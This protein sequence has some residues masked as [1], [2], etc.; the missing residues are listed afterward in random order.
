M[1]VTLDRLP[2]DPDADRRGLEADLRRALAD[3]KLQLHY[4]PVI[5]A[6]TREVAGVEALLRWQCPGRGWVPPDRF[7]PLAEEIG[8]IEPITEWVLSRAGRDLAPL[9]ALC[10]PFRLSVNLPAREVRPERVAK[11]LRLVADQHG[12][13]AERL[14]FEITERTLLG[15]VPSVHAALASL[16]AAGVSLAI[17]DFGTGYSSLSYLDRYPIGRL[18]IDKSFVQRLDSSPRGRK[19]TEAILL[20]AG[21]LD[22]ETVAEGVE[23]IDQLAFLIGKGCRYIQGYL[24]SRPLPIA[25]LATFVAGFRFPEDL[26]DAALWPQGLSLPRV[27]ADNQE[28]A[29]RLFVEHVPAAVAMFDPAMRYVAVSARWLSDHR[30]ADPDVIGRCH[31][32]VVPHTPQRSREVNARC[33]AGAVERCEEDRT[34]G[35]DGRAEWTR[36]EVRP[37]TN[38]IGDVAGIIIFS[39][40]ITERKEA[41]L[42]Q[43]ES[44]QRLADLLGVASD[45]LW[46]TD[47]EHRVIAGFGDVD[48]LRAD[49]GIQG[50]RAPDGSAPLDTT[51]G[52]GAAAVIGCRRWDQPGIEPG[53]EA[54]WRAHQAELDAHRPFRGF[55][56]PRRTRDGDLVWREVSGRPVFDH[57]GRFKGY[58]GVARDVTARERAEA[59]LRAR[60]V[61]L[62]LASEMAGLGY[63]HHDMLHGRRTLSDGL[64]RILGRD[65]GSVVLDDAGRTELV[66]PDD[67]QAFA[68]TVAAAMA[69]RAPY[70]LRVRIA[71]PDGGVR[72][73]V[74]SGRPQ[75]ADDGRLLGY[76]GVV[77][78]ITDQLGT[79]AALAHSSDENQMFRAIIEA[80]PDH[81]Y[82]K[83]LESRFLVANA[84]T[85]ALF[86]LSGPDQ[87]IGKCDHDFHPKELADRFLAEERAILR[88]GRTARFEHRNVFDGETRIVSALKA[89]LRDAAGR[90]IGLVGINRDI[91]DLVRAREQAA[92]ERRTNE[93][94]RAGIE[95]LPDLFYVKD[96]EHRFLAANRA[97][98]RQVGAARV[99]DVIGRTDADFHPPDLARTYRE[100]EAA[101]LAG[102]EP[103]LLQQPAR[104]AD[105]TPGW[106]ASLKSPLRD[107][108]GTL[109][110]LVGHASDI[111]EQKRQ[112]AALQS[113]AEELR[114]LSAMVIR[115]AQ[116]AERLRDLLAE[117]AAAVSDGVALF[118][119]QDRLVLCND[120]FSAAYGAAPA[121][122]LGRSFEELQRNPAFRARLRLDDAGFEAWL[123]KRLAAHR[124]ATGTPEEWERD[125]QWGLVRE[126]RAKDGSIVLSRA[127][128]T[129]LKRVEQDL[130]QLAARDALT[131]L[132]SRRDFVAKG[133]RLFARGAS[134]GRPAALLLFDLDHFKRIN[135]SHGHPVGDQVLRQVAGVCSG[136]V[137]P[138]DLFARWGG[139][140]F[141]LLLDGEDTK[142]AL[143]IAERLRRGI[144]AMTVR[145]GPAGIRLT[146]SFGLAVGDGQS[147]SL[148]ELIDRADHA[149]YRA[150]RAGRNRV[151][152][153]AE[154]ATDAL[155]TG[156]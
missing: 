89:P 88:D 98:A 144:A 133:S 103:V 52:W 131:G 111:T 28:Q 125:G 113:Q 25:A 141:I 66:H 85:V 110:G 16:A 4:Q 140:E 62:E 104:R 17:D 142:A 27:L 90:L 94:Y 148:D 84:A 40:R 151:E 18:K 136:L 112:E 53:N 36:W 1:T 82:A 95:L 129:H 61:Q 93:V 50:G 77:Y 132:S 39:E 108:H 42:R 20:M 49:A 115:T 46:E 91:T 128:I 149:L 121:G 29:L 24:F 92:A 41:E 60:A 34:V 117:A 138:T 71:R 122:L 72:E 8:L 64:Y 109:I 54:F 102:G 87:L 26:L 44:E 33:L 43:H 31:Y 23:T 86:G 105:G 51:A 70:R 124:I 135:D 74:T 22:V 14:E 130:R 2:A 123:D 96:L 9:M 73:V 156:G 150:K 154:Q 137:R 37:F 114:E 63:W 38:G 3:D 118:D 56:Y 145:D 76:F 15:D 6:K 12:L 21:A 134:F 78:D 155:A 106:L 7:V 147:G 99:E 116:E 55:V 59:T 119:P 83:D 146:A 69:A 120:A 100:Q 30:I 57:D 127:D 153:A 45:W 67:R 58:R 107:A 101:V 65:P 75:L 10:P 48:T 11:L 80:L 19:L 5:D 81:V 152:V 139:E 97:V 47:A 126:R 68:D 79:E 143:R 13:A 35:P 32:E